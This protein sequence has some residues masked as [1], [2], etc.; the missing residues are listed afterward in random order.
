VSEESL[1][2]LGLRTLEDIN[3]IILHSHDLL[4]TL[5]N[6]VSLVAKR[7]GTDV[8]SIYLLED[9]GE[10]LTLR[11]TRG[12]SRSAVGKITMKSSEGLTGLVVEQRGMVA[13][14]DA[15]S[16]PRYKYFKESREE[17]FHSFLGLPLMQ[18]KTPIGVI[19]I[20]TREARTFRQAEVSTL[21]T[22]AY[23]ISS[24][25][26]NAKLLDSIR[27]KEEQRA[28]FEQELERVLNGT[29]TNGR[30]KKSKGG[31]K[32]A[33]T[34]QGSPVSQG[35]SQGKISII[36]R[37]NRQ[38]SISFE[39]IRS[40]PDEMK[41]LH[42]ALEK[43]KIE[44]LYMEKRISQTLSKDDAAIFH[45]HL[46]ML[47]DRGF[48]SR[49]HDLIQ[50][51]Y[52]ASRAVREA[53]DH[54]I[55]IFSHMEDP[56]L[57]ERSADMEDIGRR[58]LDCLDGTERNRVRLREKRIIVAEDILPS[59]M[60][61]L[62]PNKIAG[63]ITERGDA[64]SHAA[65]MARSLGI[66]A[67]LGVEGLLKH[68][69]I[70][71]EVILDGNSGQ[72]FINPDTKIRSEYN[73]LQQDFGVR[74]RELD[75]LRDV[76]AETRDGVRVSLRANIGLVSDVRVALNNGAEGVGLYRTEFPYM[77]RT[78]FPDRQ[79]LYRLYR[80]VLEGF[81][82]Q[83]VTIRTLD[84]GGDKALSYF[85]FPH[86]DNPFMGWRSIRVSLERRDIFREQLA[87]ILMASHYG[88]TSLMFPMISDIEEIRTIR[89]ILREVGEELE[90]DGYPYDRNLRMGIMVELPAA[91]QIAD[92]LIR[93][94]DFFSIGTNDLIQYTLAADRNNPKVRKYYDA[95]H[96]AVLASIRRVTEVA[97]RSGKGVSLC[98]EMAADPLN[99]VMLLGMGITEFSLAA[100]TIPVVKQAL[101]RVTLP[102]ARKIAQGALV[103]ESASAVRNYLDSVRKKLEL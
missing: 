45:A 17:R 73:R 77:S 88:K 13:T 18:R 34:L 97:N 10:T 37:R 95:Y 44:T 7:V 83:P 96:P 19:V 6:I 14:D 12:L 68:I 4:E 64:N 81:A 65:I 38:N 63:I 48:I 32:E 42:I 103:L 51:E 47:E 76:P 28:F 20:Q 50:K 5:D 22:I 75:D 29:P 86:E 9:D 46:M 36:A 49:I 53:V 54:Y 71:D 93:E 16:H 90:R 31:K 1:E 39:E 41:R 26:I 60:A 80:K 102:Q 56:Y 27:E 35:F 87:G 24:I 8:C 25:I 40:V 74:R 78:S 82:P 21:T 92:I 62:D 70:R 3:T 57:R 94:V 79:F 99:A 30:S 66:P 33:L 59:D 69:G 98:G 67:V 23:Q 58:I 91:V 2:K 100:P 85:E 43:A 11:A 52:G 61:T 101:R 84:I 89:E 72:V 55:T 15:P